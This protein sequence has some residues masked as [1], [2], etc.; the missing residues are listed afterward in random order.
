MLAQLRVF[1]FSKEQRHQTLPSPSSSCR[2]CPSS[3]VRPSAVRRK[4]P[5]SFLP[6]ELPSCFRRA[7]SPVPSRFFRRASVE[8]SHGHRR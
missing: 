3:V 4:L 5:S 2:P 1:N 7:A 6:A 8:L